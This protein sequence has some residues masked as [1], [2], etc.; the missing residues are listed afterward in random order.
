M[1]DRGFY[2]VQ[3]HPEV[4]HTTP[5][6]APARA[7][8]A[9]DLRLDALWSTGNIIEDAIARVRDQVGTGKVLLGLSGGVDSSVVA[10]CCTAPSVSS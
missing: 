5:G 10:A 3:F 8:R 9:R 2:G 6:H 7:F 4:T 1:S